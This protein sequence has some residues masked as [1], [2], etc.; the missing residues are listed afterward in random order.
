M[1]KIQNPSQQLRLE[2]LFELFRNF[3]GNLAVVVQVL[4]VVTS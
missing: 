2:L 3:P 1:F 4:G